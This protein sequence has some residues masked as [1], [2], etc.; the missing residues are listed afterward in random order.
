MDVDAFA[1][2]NV[3]ESIRSVVGTRVRQVPEGA[4]A[5]LAIA[6]VIGCE[7][8]SALI[9]RV[10][11]LEA[12]ELVSALEQLVRR[13]ML[14]VTEDRLGFTHAWIRE[15]VY[16][17]LLPARRQLLH[18]EVARAYEA[19]TASGLE[20]LPATLVHHYSQ[21]KAWPEAAANARRAGE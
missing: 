14:Q 18:L 17:S 3:P 6:A 16:E 12:S 7:F 15:W 4:R 2:G 11:G 13:R 9:A 10:A 20:S 21:A 1:A 5:V 8:D 19:T